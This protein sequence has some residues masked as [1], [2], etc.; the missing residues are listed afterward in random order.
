[1]MQ[2]GRPPIEKVLTGHV[3]ETTNNRME[4]MAAAEALEG[5]SEP[6]RAAI[7]SDSAYLVNAFNDR[8]IDGWQRRGWKK[9][10]KK[11]VLNR[12][13]WERLIAQNGRHEVQWVKVK[14]H[15]GIPMNERADG[16][17]VNALN[18]GREE[19]QPG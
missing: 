14:G 2:Y 9:S 6:C 5:L 15:A 10:D 11:P 1:M 17:A 18:V 12:D 8:W 19:R 16:L 4:L 7:H 3:A 13:L